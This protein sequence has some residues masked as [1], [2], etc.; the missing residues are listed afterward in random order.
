M[1]SAAIE[2]LA[3]VSMRNDAQSSAIGCVGGDTHDGNPGAG[4]AANPGPQNLGTA[5]KAD[6]AIDFVVD[7]RFESFFFPFAETRIG[8]KFDLDIFQQDRTGCFADTGPHLVPKRCSSLESVDRDPQIFLGGQIPRRKIWPVPESSCHLQDSVF[9]EWAY[10]WVVMQCSMHRSDRGA[11]RFC[12][13][14]E[15]RGSFAHFSFPRSR[16]RPEVLQT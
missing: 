6:D 10:A 14:T 8:A 11:Q 4:S 2:P 16:R 3:S 5:G 7:G 12:N 13:V 1:R 9:G 15:S